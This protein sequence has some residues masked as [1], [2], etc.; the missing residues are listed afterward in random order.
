MRKIIIMA[1]QKKIDLNKPISSTSKPKLEVVKLLPEYSEA[2]LILHGDYYRQVQSK[3]TKSVLWHPTTIS[4][5]VLLISS[6]TYYVL[7][8][9][10][11]ISESVSEFFQITRKSRDLHIML[12]LNSLILVGF[13]AFVG[14]GS[15]F[16]SDEFR[17]ISDNLIKP[18]YT[19]DLFG[20][21]IFRYSKL[22]KE[23][24]DLKDK[25]LLLNGANSQVVLYKEEPI[26][27][28][29][30]KPLKSSDE[31]LIV[32]ITGLS[33]RKAFHPLNFEQLLIDWA[34]TRASDLLKEHLTQRKIKS[35]SGCKV[36]LMIDTYSFDEDLKKLLKANQFTRV[37]SD[38]NYNPLGEKT[39]ILNGLI[40]RLGNST[41]D[42]YAIHIVKK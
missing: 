12:L 24:K 38:H 33:V 9:Y 11:S 2:A 39:A 29:T 13:I 17:I 36:S 32:R 3:F 18:N 4:V 15:F 23:S 19:L 25:K 31:N 10:I 16:I 30:L 6:Y 14:V 41:R 42:T 8:D 7:L 26:A 27:V 21:D 35:A 1:V 34:L 20:F 5:G 28:I 22:E 37:K 40:N